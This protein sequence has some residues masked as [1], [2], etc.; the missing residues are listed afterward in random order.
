MDEKTE[1]QRKGTDLSEVMQ[2]VRGRACTGFPLQ[3]YKGGCL[4]QLPS[5][6]KLHLVSQ[7]ICKMEEIV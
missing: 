3:P 1:A 4:D 6:Q 2:S 7:G 5:M